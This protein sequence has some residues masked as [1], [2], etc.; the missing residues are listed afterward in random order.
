MTLTP[1]TPAEARHL[2][3]DGAKLIDIRDPDEH[4]REHIPGAANVPV[5]AIDCLDTGDGTV[6][7][8]CRSG[9]RTQANAARLA[10]AAGAPCYMIEGGID[11]WRRAGLDVAAD[12]RQPLELMRQVQ[13]AAGGLVL[14]GVA[15]GFL[16]DP[17]FFALSAF[18]GAG[19]MM[20][21]AT[22]WCGLA[23]LLRW[24][25]WNQ[26]MAT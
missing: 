5:A 23:S 18:V 26:R 24:M 22:G 17:G 11:A 19:L 1:V 9:A 13:L 21:G 4:A 15:L 2:I 10:A 12:R 7:F 14:L 20:A 25:P 3:Q 8:H 6:V 16:V